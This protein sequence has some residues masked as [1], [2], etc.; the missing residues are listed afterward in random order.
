M[1]EVMSLATLENVRAII[2]TGLTDE[3]LQA[4]IDRVEAEISEEIGDPY[5]DEL[6][7]ISETV[8][9]KSKNI[10]LKRPVLSV[11]SITEYS[12]LSDTTGSALTENEQFYVWPGEGRIERIGSDILWGRMVEV[13]YVPQDQNKKRVK[14]IIDLVRIDL[15]RSALSQESIGGEY[16][17]TSPANWE[18]ER[19]MI[20]RR[21]M[22]VQI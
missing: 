19:R 6:T 16:S 15:A 3:E 1:E 5:T 18:K 9:G 11:S 13:D 21:L 7:A 8:E 17:F 4:V 10:Y 14:A 20:M 22:F 2:Q 12:G